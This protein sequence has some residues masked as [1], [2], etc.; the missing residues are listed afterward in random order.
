[1]PYNENLIM[2]VDALKDCHALYEMHFTA[3]HFPEDFDTIPVPGDGKGEFLGWYLS[4]NFE[5]RYKVEYFS[6]CPQ[7]NPFT[8][9]ARWKYRGGFFDTSATVLPTEG[10]HL[11]HTE[12][13]SNYFAFIPTRS[14]QHTFTS[15]GVSFI[16]H[17]ENGTGYSSIDFAETNI[18]TLGLTA[19]KTYY[20]VMDEAQNLDFTF[21]IECTFEY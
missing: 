17:D 16:I 21:T 19:G 14:G 7:Y 1:M 15:S 12:L 20:I 13:N 9:Y 4:P 10:T 8:L 3:N 2:D 6:Q 18:T 5:S 11:L